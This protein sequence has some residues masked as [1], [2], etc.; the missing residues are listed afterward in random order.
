MNHGFIDGNK[1]IGFAATYVFLRINGLT[2]NA[3]VNATLK[4]VIGA[5]EGGTFEKNLLELWLRKHTAPAPANLNPTSR[6]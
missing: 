4:F 6:N 2:I 5:L 3:T 1:R